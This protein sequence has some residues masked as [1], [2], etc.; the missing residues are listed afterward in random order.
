M[1]GRGHIQRLVIVIRTLDGDKASRRVRSDHL[2]E[3]RKTYAAKAAD[4]VPT[5]YADVTRVL[6]NLGQRLKLRQRVLSRLLHRAANRKCPPV[7][8]NL[9]IVYV[10]VVDGKLAEGSEFGIGKGGREMTRTKELRGSPVTE[11]KPGLEEGFL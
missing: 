11:A 1:H 2:Q 7:K 8:V 4:H 6:P 3:I 5:F 9:W 10:V